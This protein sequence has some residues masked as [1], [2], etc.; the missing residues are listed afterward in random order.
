MLRKYEYG[1]QS[2]NSVQFVAVISCAKVAYYLSIFNNWR[3]YYPSFSL[4]ELRYIILHIRPHRNLFAL[5]QTSLMSVF[6]LKSGVNIHPKYVH[7]VTMFS[8]WRPM[9]YIRLKDAFFFL[10]A[11]KTDK[12][13]LPFI[14]PFYFF[15]SK[16]TLSV[17]CSYIIRS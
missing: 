16:L 2:L 12:W 3:Y 4:Q 15:F 11:T 9:L 10:I 6:H 7:S 5:L 17:N 1:L 13:H 8:S 14:M